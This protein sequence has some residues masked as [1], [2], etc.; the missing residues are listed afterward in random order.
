MRLLAVAALAFGAFLIQ[1]PARAE[2]ASQFKGY[3]QTN[4]LLKTRLI[5]P[6]SSFELGS[7]L[8]EKFSDSG[9]GLLDLLG[10]YKGGGI[11]SKYINGTPNVANLLL[12][13]VVMQGLAHDLGAVCQGGPLA[14]ELRP[15]ALAPVRQLCAWP[16]AS[17]RNES[18]LLDY[19]LATLAYDAP[20]D[21]FAAWRDEFLG[22]G[23]ETVGAEAAIEA[24]SLAMLLNAE[25]LLQ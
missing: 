25:M 23:Y 4:L 10:S 8:G 16:D 21:E 5:R 14:T 1:A 20:F 18:A 22:P 2:P 19:W 13:S 24:M 17:A 3:V 15:E 12:W 11:P 6:G 7:Y 9:L